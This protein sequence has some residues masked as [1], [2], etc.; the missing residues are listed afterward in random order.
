MKK[1]FIAIFT[2]FFGICVVF[3]YKMFL[4]GHLPIPADLLVSEYNP[5]KTYSY[6]GYT[7]GSFPNKAQYFDVLR[8]LY[9]WKTF[10]IDAIKNGQFPL[11]NPYN[12][13][14]TPLFANFQSAVLYP[15]NLIY[16]LFE[17]KFAWSFLVF[18]QPV[19]ICIFA[20]LYARKINIS[21]IGSIFTSISFAFSAFLTVWLEYNTINQVILW[22]PLGLLSIE[23]LR[24]KKTRLWAFIFV[25]SIVFSSLAGHI[26]V[27]GYILA[28]IIFYILYRV[29]HESLVFFAL[30]LV[31]AFGISCIQFIPGIE[32]ILHSARSAHS[33]D[34][35]IDKILIQPIQL[36]MLFVPDFFGSPA[37]RNYFLTDTYV[38][39]V[40]S[41]GVVPLFFIAFSLV[42]RQNKLIR[43]FWMAPLI[44]LFFTTNNPITQLFYG[45]FANSFMLGSSPTLSIFL[46]CFSLSMLAGFGVDTW[47]AKSISIKQYLRFALFLG[48]IF[49]LLWIFIFVPSHFSFF[50]N[51][52]HIS[53]AKRN[54]L[55]PTAIFLFSAV[56]L[57]IGIQ[58][59]RLQFIVIIVLVIVQSAD[60]FKSFQ[61]FNPFSP[62]ELI[63]PTPPI[64]SYL[65]NQT[66]IDRF[67][68]YG[69]G[70]IEANFATKYKLFSPDG[71]DPLY[72]KRYGEF[73]QS[74]RNGKIATEF[75]LQNRSDAVITS[76]FGE[77]DLPSNEH[78]LR[79]LDLLGVKYILDRVENNSTE[80][81]FPKN[82]FK[83]LKEENG[84]KVLENIKASPRIF[85]ISDYEIVNTKEEF[86]KLFFNKNFD[87]SKTII[88]ENKPDILIERNTKD[89]SDTTNV[90][91][92]KPNEIIIST[93]SSHNKLLFLSDVYFPG[94]KA[95][96]DDKQVLIL[97][98]DYVFRSISIPS[99]THLV[100][101]VY[102]PMSFSIGIVISIISLLFFI[103]VI[104]RIKAKGV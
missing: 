89:N 27:F 25:A 49:I 98:A 76:G 72:P 83:I 37:T 1:E 2:I 95:T 99:G 92:Y 79:V 85:L 61:K 33:L 80:N 5:W 41:I 14:G 8:Q 65:K 24:E 36:I 40:T 30:L 13:S 69:F 39:K 3:F 86:E 21:I 28:F 62:Q 11:W 16:L 78:R 56:V 74:S 35:F 15:F 20:Y 31:T 50:Q 54:L 42:K 7:P 58:K 10:A 81:T 52:A 67:W 26:Q 12:F 93:K 46:V 38:G 9:P 82:R 43:F 68:G 34:F 60:L 96:I 48:S 84:W 47:L 57:F 71:Y 18:L 55:L 17:Q 101:F 88:L 77:N 44:I 66:R 73:I 23:H 97:R 4:Y 45:I 100:K 53:V 103:A 29:K 75:T 51:N 32:L 104:H 91:L 94:W 87:P 64:F 22:L 19:L 59:K 6:L 70:S 90:L 102:K 63:F